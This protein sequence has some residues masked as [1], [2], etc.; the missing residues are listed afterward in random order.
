MVYIGRLS[1]WKICE[2][3]HEFFW[4]IFGLKEVKAFRPRTTKLVNLSDL[5][6]QSSNFILVNRLRS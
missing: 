2:Y 3:L 1:V 5:S 4:I 6:S